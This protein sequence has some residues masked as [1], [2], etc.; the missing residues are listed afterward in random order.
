MIH[1]KIN[2]K[3]SNKKCFVTCRTINRDYSSRHHVEKKRFY[4]LQKY[5]MPIAMRPTFENIVS[6]VI[7]LIKIISMPTMMPH[8]HQQI[9]F[10]HSWPVTKKREDIPTHVLYSSIYS[11]LLLKV[12][13]LSTG[14][15]HCVRIAHSKLRLSL[16]RYVTWDRWKKKWSQCRICIDHRW[17]LWRCL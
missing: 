13:L 14:H 8:K 16:A 2:Q 3:L 9:L 6:V 10:R 5:A 4:G 7:C 17:L 1:F 15:G 11:L 12:P